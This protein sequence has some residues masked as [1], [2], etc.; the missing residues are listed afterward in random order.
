MS[1]YP[2]EII[3]GQYG[4]KCVISNRT[5]SFLAVGA[6][7]VGGF[8]GLNATLNA[9][10]TRSAPETL[11]LDQSPSR[12][13]CVRN[14][15]DSIVYYNVAWGSEQ[16]E[17]SLGPRMTEMHR[18]PDVVAP[19]LLF[20]DSALNDAIAY[21]VKLRA[22]PDGDETACHAASYVFRYPDKRDP[23]RLARRGGHYLFGNG[24]SAEIY[25][26]E[27]LAME[28]PTLSRSLE[29]AQ[30]EP[31]GYEMIPGPDY[32]AEMRGGAEYAPNY[33]PQTT[34]APLPAVSYGSRAQ[35]KTGT[36]SSR[37]APQPP[38]VPLDKENAPVRQ[39]SA[40][41]PAAKLV[42]NEGIAD[43]ESEPLAAIY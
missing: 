12:A 8:I 14:D 38:R 2:F 43:T 30:P 4:D 36:G 1:R 6:I 13:F 23:A 7:G 16:E 25:Q 15:T 21:K 10:E 32:I 27:A 5:L 22:I 19:F 42:A 40:T 9:N 26:N 37:V 39:D 34:T 24:I 33:I 41:P 35:P 31:A 17:H 20:S 3:E 11:A 18:G 29:G 28:D